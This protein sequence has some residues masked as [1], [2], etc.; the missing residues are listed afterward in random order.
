MYTLIYSVFI[1]IV[2]PRGPK[3]LRLDKFLFRCHIFYSLCF[4]F[5]VACPKY[6]LIV[7]APSAR[8]FGSICCFP[9]STN[10]SKNFEATHSLDEFI[11]CILRDFLRNLTMLLKEVQFSTFVFWVQICSKSGLCGWFHD[12][13]ALIILSWYNAHCSLWFY[14]SRKNSLL[15]TSEPCYKTA[16]TI[17]TL[18]SL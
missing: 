9:S 17:S 11:Y 16:S 6:S 2:V 18:S 1:C 15:S 13:S 7:I 8:C 3:Y 5:V 10:V 14:C 4:M 12:I